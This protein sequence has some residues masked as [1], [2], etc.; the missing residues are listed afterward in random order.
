MKRVLFTVL[1]AATACA[2]N[3]TQ[4]QTNQPQSGSIGGVVRDASTNLPIPDVTVSAGQKNSVT[5]ANGHYLLNEVPPGS[6]R[7]YIVPDFRADR[8]GV[9]RNVVLGP[10][11]DL[12]SVDLLIRPLG[13]ISGKVVDQNHEPVPGVTVSLVAR[14]YWLGALRYNFVGLATTD[15]QGNYVLQRV[16]PGRAYL[17]VAHKRDIKLEPISSSPVN[18]KLRRPAWVPT[19]FPGTPSL[20]GAQPLTL[21]PGER[22]QGIDIQVLRSSSFC[23]EGMVQ[24]PL[25]GGRVQFQISEPQPSYGTTGDSGTYGGLP[26]GNPADD[27]KIRICN[28]HPGE[29]QLEVFTEPKG[30]DGPAFYGTMPV[31]VT[32]Q[33]LDRIA[34]APLPRVPLTAEVVWDGT[35]PNTSPDKTSLTRLNINVESLTRTERIGD[36]IPIPGSVALKDMAIDDYHVEVLGGI[37]TGA[38]V[39][40]ITYGDRS[41]LHQPLR[42]GTASGQAPLRVVLAAGGGR[43]SAAAMDKDGNPVPDTAVVAFPESAKSE[44][45]LADVMVTGRTDQNGTWS[46]GVLA[47]GKYEVIAPGLPP[48]VAVDRSPETLGKLLRA[49]SKAQEVDLAA[50]ASAQVTLTPTPLD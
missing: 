41:V 45:A 44:V 19:Y 39:K 32:D 30:L 15:D 29:Y 26:G 8:P 3:Q 21:T 11:Q 50:S 13:E 46:S 33:D 2:Q 25:G 1:V 22:R 9:T 43:I 36:R 4:P 34:A 20:D 16:E 31:V 23:L 6:V 35:P 38:Y 10:G 5:D 49:R 42:G 48:G 40:D 7:I 47:P 27:G 24:S 18:P 12:T 17:V 37:P 28:L 14:Q